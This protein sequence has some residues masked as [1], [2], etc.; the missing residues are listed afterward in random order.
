MSDQ[1][2]Q[3]PNSPSRKSL[4]N[5]LMGFA[6]PAIRVLEFLLPLCSDGIR[7]IRGEFSCDLDS[8]AEESTDPPIKKRENTETIPNYS[9]DDNI[10]F[11]TMDK[12]EKLSLLKSRAYSYVLHAFNAESQAISSVIKSF[13]FYMH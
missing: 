9:V 12:K 6:I 3:A 10:L 13:L 8:V 4:F 1:K 5:F 7:L 11:G 2:D